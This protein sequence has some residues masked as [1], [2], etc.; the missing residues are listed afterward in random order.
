M[1]GGREALLRL[2]NRG[3]MQTQHAVSVSDH[4]VSPGL[5]GPENREVKAERRDSRLRLEESR[6][7]S[8]ERPPAKTHGSKRWCCSAG[9]W[10]RMVAARGYFPAR[11]E[12]G[13]VQTQHAVG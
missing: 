6:P 13:R 9:S 1:E 8:G 10:R 12:R 11:R 7:H 2:S 3:S 5:H 4:T